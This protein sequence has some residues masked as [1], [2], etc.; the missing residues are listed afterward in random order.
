MDNGILPKN[1][2][3]V[4]APVDTET[5][6]PVESGF[7]SPRDDSKGFLGAYFD[8]PYE[9]PFRKRERKS[10]EAPDGTTLSG[11]VDKIRG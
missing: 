7:V 8:G 6:N 10:P 5:K 2:D 3:K 1:E 11:L 9:R 4:H